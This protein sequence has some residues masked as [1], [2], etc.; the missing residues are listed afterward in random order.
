MTTLPIALFYSAVQSCL[1]VI[2]ALLLV[3]RIT[4]SSGLHANMPAQVLRPVGKSSNLLA[5]AAALI[6][7]G[8]KLPDT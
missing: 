6:F 7:R 5:T 2:G 8:D 4:H 1:H 3:R